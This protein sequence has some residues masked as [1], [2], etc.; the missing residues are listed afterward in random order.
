VSP[1]DAE[2]AQ[3]EGMSTPDRCRAIRQRRRHIVRVKRGQS[4]LLNS[5]LRYQRFNPVIGLTYKITL[6]GF[7]GELLMTRDAAIL[8]VLLALVVLAL[9]VPAT[10]ASSRHRRLGP[11]EE[12]R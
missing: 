10:A 12:R 8:T 4:P 5:H 9:F 6:N 7:V 3:S 11:D 1:R 2:C